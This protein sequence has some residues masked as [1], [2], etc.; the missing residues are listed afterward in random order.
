M[1]LIISPK[2]EFFSFGSSDLD[3]PAA[4]GADLKGF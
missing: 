2:S 3:H 4:G 1:I